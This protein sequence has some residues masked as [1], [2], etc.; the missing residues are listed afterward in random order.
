MVHYYTQLSPSKDLALEKTS[1]KSSDTGKY[2][3]NPS[4][5][6]VY[7]NEKTMKEPLELRSEKFDE[8]LSPAKEELEDISMADMMSP[9]PVMEMTEQSKRADFSE[10]VF[11]D[12]MYVAK[13]RKLKDTSMA[14]P[15]LTFAYLDEV[16]NVE[17]ATSGGTMKM[18]QNAI[19]T[20]AKKKDS[21]T[22]KMPAASNNNI[23]TGNAGYE[24]KDTVSFKPEKSLAKAEDDKKDLT[25]KNMKIEFW[26]SPVNFRGYK[27]TGNTVQLY[28][29]A[30]NNVRLFM[31]NNKL[32]LRTDGMVYVLT[33]CS[34]GCAY[35]SETNTTITDIIIQQP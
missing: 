3:V 21:Y 6:D 7:T 4:L 12:N 1:A 16:K 15:V 19:S 33:T 32:Y 25:V 18:T 26:Q 5:T 29:L 28:G 30:S 27:Y 14:L 13:D 34:E 8:V 35:Q 2:P 17:L 22:S 11:A 24:L 9:P 20:R 23:T 10:D 31:L